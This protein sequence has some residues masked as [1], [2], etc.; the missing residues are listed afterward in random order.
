[1]ALQPSQLT[2]VSWCHQNCDTI[3]WTIYNDF[4]LLHWLGCSAPGGQHSPVMRMF[5]LTSVS[6]VDGLFMYRKCRK[7]FWSFIMKLRNV[8]KNLWKF[9]FP[10]SPAFSIKSWYLS[11]SLSFTV[12]IF[13]LSCIMWTIYPS[14]I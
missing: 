4:I 7:K 13:I 10:P 1:M 6:E 5:L 12:N 8:K 3:T 2:I 9:E 11:L 14:F